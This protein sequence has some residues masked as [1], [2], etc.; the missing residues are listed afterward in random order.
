MRF[1]VT[2]YT[3]SDDTYSYIITKKNKGWVVTRHLNEDKGI[4]HMYSIYSMNGWVSIMDS[5][6]TK[7]FNSFDEV[8]E[9]NIC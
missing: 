1:K 4:I 3:G 9:E 5:Y 6:E 2:Q 8:S 7:Y